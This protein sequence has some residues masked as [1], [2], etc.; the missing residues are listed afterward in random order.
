MKANPRAG[1]LLARLVDKSIAKPHDKASDFYDHPQYR[2]TFGG[3]SRENFER[4]LTTR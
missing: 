1:K 3:V 2:S 4:H